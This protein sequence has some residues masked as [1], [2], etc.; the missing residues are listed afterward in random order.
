MYYSNKSDI[1]RDAVGRL[2]WEKEID[3]LPNTGDSVQEVREIRNRLSKEKF[4]FWDKNR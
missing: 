1:I 2:V 3:T 4:D